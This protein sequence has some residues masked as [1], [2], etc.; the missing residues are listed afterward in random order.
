MANITR[1]YPVAIDVLQAI[2]H[3]VSKSLL[4]N[5]PNGALFYA[6]NVLS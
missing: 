6:E 4:G 3:N 1:D 5:I 2:G